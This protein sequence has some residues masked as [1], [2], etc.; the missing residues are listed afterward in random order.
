MPT[1]PLQS[2]LYRELS[3]VEAKDLI[4]NASP[5]LKELINYSTNAFARCQDSATGAENED[6]AILIL[7][8]HII[9][10]TDGVETLIAQSCPVPAIPLIRSSFEAVLS[11]EYIL[12]TDYEVRSLSWL[13]DY[14]RNRLAF[15]DL[16]DPQT[17]R[18]N[19]FQKS[20]M[21]DDVA[22]NIPLPPLELVHTSAEN[23]R[24]FLARPQFQ[25]IQ[26]E[27]ERC[28]KKLKRKPPWYSL[29][30]GPRNIQQLAH[31][32]RQG[33]RYD[34]LYRQLSMISHAQ[35]VSRF[36]AGTTA[37]EPAFKALRGSEQINE[38]ATFA[39]VSILSA[40]RLALGKFRP[41]ENISSWYKAEVREHFLSVARGIP[42]A[43][44]KP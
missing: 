24:K 25:P 30:G 40:T 17:A 27:F 2:L 10:M 29:F 16:V 19:A 15:Y 36:M 28:K 37:G 7:Y 13:A 38:I 9:E 44:T 23:L 43:V 35:D 4:A 12:E 41:G 11:M 31:N 21:S 39:S 33:A 6:L 34:V 42:G 8:L 14:A 20:R 5:L 22:K 3:K 18:G 32:R 1:K 26:V